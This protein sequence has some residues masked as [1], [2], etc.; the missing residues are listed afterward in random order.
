MEAMLDSAACRSTPV[1]F[2]SYNITSIRDQ[3][4]GVAWDSAKDPPVG[5]TIGNVLAGKA[6]LFACA[7]Q[8][9]PQG[10]MSTERQ[11]MLASLQDG[12]QYSFWSLCPG[13]V[14]LT[15]GRET[16]AI[17]LEECDFQS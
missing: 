12:P 15:L 3:G 9:N 14:F 16:T 7:I 13:V 4:R 17:W 10:L 1:N 2:M 11:T 8:I 6:M 5:P